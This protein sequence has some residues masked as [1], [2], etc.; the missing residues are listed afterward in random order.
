MIV[1]IFVAHVYPEVKEEF[2]IK[3]REIS[4]PITQNASGLISLEIAGPIESSSNEFLM[5]SRW[6]SVDSIEA[7]VGGNW[8]KAFI[9][10]GMEDYI[11]RCTVVHF[12]GID[13][14]GR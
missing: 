12:K 11:E 1:R 14:D 4:V 8:N 13:L 10:K 3:F 6:N 5:I 7:F 9:P 2:E